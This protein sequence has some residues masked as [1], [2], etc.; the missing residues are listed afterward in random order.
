MSDFQGLPT[1]I[2]RN[3]LVHLEYLVGAEPRIVRLSAFGKEN[4][5][6]DIPNSVTTPYGDFFFRGGHRLW[7]APEE[8]PRSY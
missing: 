5:F 8:M 2:L 7:H 6:A 1:R 4:L 3:D